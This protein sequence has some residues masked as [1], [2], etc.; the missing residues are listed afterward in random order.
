MRGGC[1]Q[2]LSGGKFAHACHSACS[3]CVSMRTYFIFTCLYQ[4]DSK[5]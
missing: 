5:L 4:S 2:T 3:E 1:E